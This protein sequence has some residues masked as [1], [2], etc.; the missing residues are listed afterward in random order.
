MCVA[1]TKEVLAGHFGVFGIVPECSLAPFEAKVETPLDGRPG[2]NPFKPVLEAGKVFELLTQ[3]F[4]WNNPV[5]TGPISTTHVRYQIATAEIIPILEARI[6]NAR[7]PFHFIGA[8]FDSLR[9][10][11]AHIG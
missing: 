5:P 1:Q 6:H 10:F 4:V 3:I 8:S 11:F 9:N 2:T 7:K